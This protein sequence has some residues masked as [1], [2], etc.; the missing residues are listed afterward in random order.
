MLLEDEFGMINLIV[1]PPVAERCRTAVR[2][3]GFVTA[4]GRLE[5][6][7][8]TTN[9]VV[10]SIE[11]LERDGGNLPQTSP[12]VFAPRSRARPDA[13]T[14]RTPRWPTRAVAGARSA[15]ERRRDGRSWASWIAPAASRS[16]PSWRRRYR[17]GT[18]SGGAAARSALYRP[19]LVVIRKM[20]TTRRMPVTVPAIPSI[21]SA[22]LIV[23]GELHLAGAGV[24][25]LLLHHRQ[26]PPVGG[27]EVG[28]QEDA[29][30]D[31]DREGGADPEVAVFPVAL[32]HLVEPGGDHDHQRRCGEEL[33]DRQLEAMHVGQVPGPHPHRDGKHHRFGEGRAEADHHRGDVNEDRDLVAADGQGHGGL[34]SRGC[35]RKL[36]APRL[37]CKFACIF[38]RNRVFPSEAG[39]SFPS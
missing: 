36:P 15:S 35:A 19:G 12:R 10:A 21:P 37:A 9:V 7:E 4:R 28:E 14:R 2:T 3:A 17:R 16:W 23:L 5:H 25:D 26:Q 30:H 11:R 31:D 38:A 27:Y 18:R 24:G 39:P 33:V 6:R 8:G 20:A 1:P 22:A 29:D 13:P 32:G 34:L